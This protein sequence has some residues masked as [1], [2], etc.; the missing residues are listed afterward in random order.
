MEEEKIFPILR[1]FDYLWSKDPK[2]NFCDIIKELNNNK[3]EYL[4][5]S[6]LIDKLK[7]I[8]PDEK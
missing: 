5:D 4:T 3:F 8:N 6:E 7:D 1:K 2:K